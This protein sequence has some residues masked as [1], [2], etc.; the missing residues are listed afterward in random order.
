MENLVEAVSLGSSSIETNAM[1]GNSDEQRSETL[2]RLEKELSVIRQA[3]GL[4]GLKACSQCGKFYRGSD[5]G[6]LFE[7]GERVCVSG[8]NQWWPQRCQQLS[9][10]DREVVERRLVI[11]LTN[12][13][14]AKVVQQ[15]EK[16]PTDAT[17]QFEMVAGCVQCDGIGTIS[18]KRCQACGGRG[19]VWVIVP[20]QE[21]H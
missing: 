19:T 7:A 12:Y 13:H 4:V 11:W 2:A 1:S 15:H 5:T 21:E 3:L 8:L 18:D 20:K 17:R 6:A 14:G 16:L 10:K 9:V